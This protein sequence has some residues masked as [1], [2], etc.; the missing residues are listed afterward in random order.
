VLSFCWLVAEETES[1]LF[2]VSCT[3]M[4]RCF[5]WGGKPLPGVSEQPL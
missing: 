2:E 5:E 3:G 4:A 1:E